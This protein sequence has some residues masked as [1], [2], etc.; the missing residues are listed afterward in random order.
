MSA[1][2]LFSMKIE[3]IKKLTREAYETASLFNSF[4]HHQATM[5]YLDARAAARN[6]RALAEEIDLLA[7]KIAPVEQMQAAE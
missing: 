6:A 2:Q 4:R 5:A 7:D 1:A 3:R